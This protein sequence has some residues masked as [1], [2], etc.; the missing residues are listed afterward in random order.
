MTAKYI[1]VSV[2][3]SI[4]NVFPEDVTIGLSSYKF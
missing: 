1:E 3:G 2:I 4:Q